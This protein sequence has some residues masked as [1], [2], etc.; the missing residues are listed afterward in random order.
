M[1]LPR[2]AITIERR[3]EVRADLT[4]DGAVSADLAP[5]QRGHE[6]IC[7]VLGTVASGSP[8]TRAE[9]LEAVRALLGI[10]EV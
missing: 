4:G 1:I 5:R 3:R 9:V 8:V 6:Y 10:E 2:N 7:L